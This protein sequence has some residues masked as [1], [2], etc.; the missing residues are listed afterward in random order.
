MKLNLLDKIKSY[1]SPQAA[2]EI[3]KFRSASALYGGGLYDGATQSPHYNIQTFDT[4][5]DED[6]YDLQT[7]RA[8]SREKYKN[9]G[10][11]RG[12]IQCATDHVIGSG[13]RAKSTIKRKLIPN[14]TED[15]AK[16][17]EAILDDYFNSWAKSTICDITAKDNFF[18]LQRLAYKVYKKDGD[19][20]ASLPLTKVG[21]SKVIQVNLI[22]AE[23][24]E[25][26]KLGFTEG[27]KLSDNKMPLS[28]SIK[29]SNNT[30]KEIRAFSKGKRNILHVF[31]RERAKSVRGIPFLTPVM[32]DIDAIDQFMK[33]ELNAAKLAAIFFGSIETQSKSDVF[34]ND[35]NLLTGEQT[36]TTSNTVKENTITQLAPNDKLNIH[37]QGRD[38]PNFDKYIQ[39]NLR[40]VSTETRIPLEIILT[41]FVSSY[42]ASRA[43]MLQMSK[44]I[45]P[46]R[47]TFN[48]S[49]NKPI[50]E[51]VIVWGILQGD[52]IIP[53]FF[54][55]KT[56]YLE[57]MW[58]GDAMGSVDP[59]KDIKAKVLAIDN[60]LCTRELATSDLGFGD[61]E[62]NADILQK[63]KELLLEKKL[64]IEETEDNG[65]V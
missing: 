65:E 43:A 23:N 30:Y 27:I 15:R 24:I 8:T 48:N 64:I 35:T 40:K 51:Q 6:I 37:N 57:A 32:R 63:E 52:I 62:T 54:E 59:T 12:V 18:S 9:N 14:L 21:S 46:E 60:N 25:S 38:N 34:G 20:F 1:V 22:G 47:M 16:E 13:I 29:Q 5:E 49:F 33:Y 31:E 45:N 2:Y 10:F 39:T 19:S 17:I 11:Y 36:Q 42:S 53:D 44:F 41:Q 55:H 7:L 28:Y 50:R 26:N 3:A 61:F 4:T 58:I 56:A